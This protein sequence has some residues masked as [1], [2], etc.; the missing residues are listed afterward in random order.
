MFQY[1]DKT[2]NLLYFVAVVQHQHE[3]MEEQYAH[4]KLAS[5]ELWNWRQTVQNN[6]IDGVGCCSPV[7]SSR[8]CVTDA[9]VKQQHIAP[10]GPVC[11]QPCCS[12]RFSSRCHCE[13]GTTQLGMLT[14]DTN[15]M[16]QLGR[17]LLGIVP[18]RT[19][20]LCKGLSS[21]LAAC[22][23][24]C[25][26]APSCGGGGVSSTVSTASC[27]QFCNEQLQCCQHRAEVTLSC[28]TILRGKCPNHAVPHN[29]SNATQPFQ[30]CMIC[31]VLQE[32]PA[33]WT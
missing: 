10:G 1:L 14:Q 19:A 5:Y 25:N 13:L 3:S 6:P 12:C 27:L 28:I 7:G 18:I 24:L 21:S 17:H 22:R 8:R 15:M 16:L 29:L 26:E 23:C 9:V 11:P 31:T 2:K 20:G 33:S 4:I 32:N 30:T